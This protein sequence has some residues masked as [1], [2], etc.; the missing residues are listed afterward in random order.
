[1]VRRLFCNHGSICYFIQGDVHF[2]PL[3]KGNIYLPFVR[4]TYNR[5]DLIVTLSLI[6]LTLNQ[7]RST[8]LR[9]LE[10]PRSVFIVEVFFFIRCT[11]RHTDTPRQQVNKLTSYID[12]SVVYGDSEIRNRALREFKD[13]KM[14]LGPDGL[15]PVSYR[16]EN[17]VSDQSIQ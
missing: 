4:S 2:D 8:Y 7:R 6:L 15:I 9:V 11:G 17:P 13:G 5:F 12:G 1:M 16:D 3:D 14:K 10:E